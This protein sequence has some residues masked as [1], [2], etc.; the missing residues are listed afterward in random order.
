LI[1]GGVKVY[2]SF[3]SAVMATPFLLLPFTLTTGVMTVPWEEVKMKA[4]PSFIKIVALVST[5]AA[6]A[7]AAALLARRRKH[8]ASSS[9]SDGMVRDDRSGR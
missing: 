8:V 1:T 6:T 9:R 7:S 2:M 4:G 5:C 3:P